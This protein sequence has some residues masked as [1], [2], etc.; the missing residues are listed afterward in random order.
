MCIRDRVKAEIFSYYKEFYD[1][2]GLYDEN[3]GKVYKYLVSLA[4]C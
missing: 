2:L 4:E 3:K 1:S